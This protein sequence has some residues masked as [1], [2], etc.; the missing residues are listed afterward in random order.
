MRASDK[1]TKRQAESGK[2]K[3][4]SEK[5]EATKQASMARDDKASERDE[6][7]GN[8]GVKSGCAIVPRD[9]L[10]GNNRRARDNGF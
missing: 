9:L 1:A 6:T 7:Q 3:A 10:L 4:E 2:R 5:R 8:K